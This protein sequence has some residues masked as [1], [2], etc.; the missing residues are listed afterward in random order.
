MDYRIS[1]NKLLSNTFFIAIVL[2]LF[3]GQTKLIYIT[4]ELLL[5]IMLLFGICFFQNK[6]H[7]KN[8]VWKKEIIFFFLWGVISYTWSSYGKAEKGYYFVF[9]AMIFIL[10]ISIRDDFWHNLMKWVVIFSN[11]VAASIFLEALSPG[12]FIKLFGWILALPANALSSAMKGEYTGILGGNQQAAVFLNIGIAVHIAYCYANRKL[13]KKSVMYIFVY[14]IAIILTSKRML[15]VIPVVLFL[16]YYFMS[17]TK[18]KYTKF[19]LIAFVLFIILYIGINLSP[20]YSDKILGYFSGEDESDLLSGRGAFWIGCVAMFAE[21]PVNGYGLASFNGEYFARTHYLFKGSPWVYHAHN[22]YYQML[23]ELGIIGFGLFVL[24]ALKVI[25]KI[26]KFNKEKWNLE[27]EQRQILFWSMSIVIIF[28]IYGL[29]GNV[30]YNTEEI[31]W[32][33]MGINGISYVINKNKKI[34]KSRK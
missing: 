25:P 20:E 2:V 28:L 17:T 19:F 13:D 14:L 4:N 16:L 9:I 27:K 7:L 22:I 12:I 29:T 31:C 10:M 1:M 34:K 33:V 11:V 23:A 32:Y 15:T 8:F 30:L 24:Q 21:K 26:Y 6:V 3:R 18:N 5:V